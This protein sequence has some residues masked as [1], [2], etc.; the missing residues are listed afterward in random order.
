[1]VI[2]GVRADKPYRFSAFCDRT[3]LPAPGVAGGSPGAPGEY[4]LTDHERPNPKATVWVEPEAEIE[5]G[6][7][8]G[9]GFGDPFTRDPDQVCADVLDGYV[10]AERARADYGVVLVAGP[11]GTPLVDLPATERLR[12]ARGG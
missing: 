9:G 2:K 7:P 6:L 11:N 4:K 12:A 3:A 10:S 8:G 1:V 5:L